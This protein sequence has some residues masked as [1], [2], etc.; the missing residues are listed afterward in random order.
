M[1]LVGIG[2]DSGG[3]HTTFAVKRGD[4]SKPAAMAE[5]SSTLSDARSAMSMRRAAE[6]MVSRVADQV[7]P[8]DE[9]CV[10]IGAAAGIAATTTSVFEQA[11]E[12]PL[13]QLAGR[14]I[15]CEI[16]IAND[17]ASILKS[18]PLHGQGIVAIVGTGSIVVGAHPACP[19]GIIRR[20]GYDGWLVIAGA[21][22]DD[23]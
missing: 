6:W 3:T 14:N 10:W 13:H 9:C 11:F 22:L 1:A 7:R 17:A 23:F 4:D 15:D 8:G 20:G 12:V 2:I 5:S 16:F 21:H 19:D 18:P